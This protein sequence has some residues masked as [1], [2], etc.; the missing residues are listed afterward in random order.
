MMKQTPR[1]PLLKKLWSDLNSLEQLNHAT[2]RGAANILLGLR[3]RTGLPLLER[4][5]LRTPALSLYSFLGNGL[6][7]GLLAILALLTQSPFVYPGL[8]PTGFL[9][10]S[11]TSSP[12]ACPRNAI[13]GNAIALLV[14]YLC[15]MIT[16][17]TEA[18]SA[19]TVGFTWPRMIA[20]ALSIA[21]TSGLLD[22]FHVQHP[23]AG[24]S[25]LVVSLGLITTP[26]K[27]GIVLVSIILLVLLAIVINRLA[28]IQYP[29]WNPLPFRVEEE[30]IAQAKQLA[31]ES[32]EE[33]PEKSRGN[34]D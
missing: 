11:L 33:V 23:P 20:V 31:H 4:R 5:S 28:G 27:L 18:G 26:W 16:G 25:T 29:L 21:L 13:I 32:T 14:G 15:L 19:L 3:R 22:L 1:E 6:S 8:G 10:F 30:I 7:L 9:L 17:L 24:A 34:T 12:M 2:G